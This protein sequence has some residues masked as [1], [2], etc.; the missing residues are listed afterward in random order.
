[1]EAGISGR[2]SERRSA[3]IARDRQG[4]PLRIRGS[5][6]QDLCADTPTV[7]SRLR[8]G[9]AARNGGRLV[10]V[11]F[12]LTDDFAGKTATGTTTAI[13]VS[14]SRITGHEFIPTAGPTTA[15]LP[16]IVRAPCGAVLSGSIS[17]GNVELFAEASP[18]GRKAGELIGT[19]SCQQEQ[20][21]IDPRCSRRHPTLQHKESRKRRAGYASQKEN[22]GIDCQRLTLEKL[23]RMEIQPG[24]GHPQ[25]NSQ[26]AKEIGFLEF[27]DWFLH[28]LHSLLGNDVFV[29]RLDCT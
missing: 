4:I 2:A 14:S 16:I 13:L 18:T 10:R 19:E 27:N 8:T 17:G 7:I 12:L 25:K 23:W 20:N 15:R 29:K 21:G 3:N 22:D 6:R 24:E 26:Q 28:V 1:M 5:Q 9:D 11:R